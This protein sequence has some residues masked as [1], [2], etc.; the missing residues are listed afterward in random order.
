MKHILIFAI[1]L[2]AATGCSQKQNDGFIT[3]DVTKSSYPKKE[4]VLQDFYGCGI[5][6]AGNK[7]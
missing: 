4:L 3:V 1:V 7:R 6:S 2:L 5:Y